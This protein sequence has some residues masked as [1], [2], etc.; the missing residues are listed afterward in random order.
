MIALN[1]KPERRILAQFAWVAAIAFPLLAGLFTRGDARW[2]APWTWSW[3]HPVVLWLAAVGVVQLLAFLAGVQVLT[4]WL[5]VVLVT[6]SWPI[7]F[8]LSHVLMGIVFYLVI[9]PMGLAF[10]L[11]GRDAMGRKF[12]PKVASYWHRRAKLRE[13]K[14]YFKL[15]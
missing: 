3:S 7:G 12:D 6:I 2:F 14:S 8:L 15:Y 1:L 13:P 4:R 11:V 10:K 5:Y 9:T